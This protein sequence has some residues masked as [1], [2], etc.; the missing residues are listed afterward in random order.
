MT[1]IP[2]SRSARAMTLAPRS[3]PSRPGLAIR[4]RIGRDMREGSVSVDDRD[5][6]AHPEPV[7]RQRPGMDAESPGPP[8]RDRGEDSR[9]P[10]GRLRVEASHQAAFARTHDLD[11]D[12][13]DPE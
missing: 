10:L 13:A 11:E 7:A 6:I 1:S 3:W 8:P 4:T 9:R 12:V 5:R 2:A